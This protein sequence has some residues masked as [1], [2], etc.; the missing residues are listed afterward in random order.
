[1]TT[2]HVEI[3][4]G[5]LPRLAASDVFE[6]EAVREAGALI[7][8]E[9]VVRPMENG[10]PLAA[11]AYEAYEPM[12]HR[13]LTELAQRILREHALLGIFVQHSRGRVEVGQVSFR[14]VIAAPHRQEG[15]AAQVSFIDDLKRVV[16]I[17]K[18]PV[19]L[20]A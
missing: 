14:L 13:Q 3:V 6:A 5:A 2:C 20:P 10:R 9:G 4:S 11:L 7:C 12:T 16:P 18:T 17:W 19:W 15:F 8:F 1:M